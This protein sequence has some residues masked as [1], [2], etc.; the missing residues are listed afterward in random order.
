M[1][2]ES[3]N[4]FLKVQQKAPIRDLANLV[5]GHADGS[6]INSQD[7]PT[8]LARQYKIHPTS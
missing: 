6:I 5:T 2:L 7:M 1:M 4:L 3:P 8:L